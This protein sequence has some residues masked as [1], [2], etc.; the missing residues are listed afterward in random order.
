MMIDLAEDKQR[1]GNNLASP[2]RVPLDADLSD[3]VVSLPL[4]ARR[5]LQSKSM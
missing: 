2:W 1:E 5:R 4:M 3:N